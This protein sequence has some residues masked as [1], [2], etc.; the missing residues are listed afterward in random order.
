ME[1]NRFEA[2]AE[3][4]VNRVSLGIQ[5]LDEA[6]LKFL[7]RQHSV[8]EAKQAILTAQ[9]A[10]SRVS[11][12]LIYAL[13]QQTLGQWEN[14]LKEALDFGTDHLSLYQLTI[15][16]GT[17]FAP[18]HARGAFNLPED[19]LAADLYYLTTDVT[20]AVGLNA[21]EV[22]NYAR[23]G[24]ECRH[25][26]VYWQ[27]GDY[28][29]VGP[30]AHGRLSCSSQ[31]NATRQYKAPETWLNKVLNYETGQEDC[32]KLSQKEECVEALMMGLRLFQPLSLAAL[33]LKATEILDIEA[34]F[35]LQNHGL[36]VYDRETLEIT[37]AGMIV[38]NSIL[39]KIIKPL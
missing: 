19:D 11:F 31:K 37:K 17:A 6:A 34:I 4:G 33:P 26:L 22:S 14:Q 24:F 23:K 9:A 10:F 35:S 36:I 39:K 16:P 27:Y 21:Y 28:A 5:S 30:G 32:L 13:P 18:L 38:L 7:G 1:I 15:E 2:L 8:S 20:A 29:G 12:D 3:A 25:N